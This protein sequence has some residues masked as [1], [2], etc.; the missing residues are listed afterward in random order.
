MHIPIF[1]KYFIK[2][3][4]QSFRDRVVVLNDFLYGMEGI[5]IL[6]IHY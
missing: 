1:D 2:T 4:S 5:F 3:K 6:T